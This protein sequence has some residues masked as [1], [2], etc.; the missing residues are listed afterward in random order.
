ML[1]SASA[2]LNLVQPLDKCAHC[3]LAL[4]PLLFRNRAVGDH[5]VSKFLLRNWSVDGTL[6]AYH[7]DSYTEHLI[8]E[9]KGL[10]TICQQRALNTMFGVPPAEKRAVE[11][12]FT[13]RVDTPA[14]QALKMMLAE[15]VGALPASYREAWAKFLIGLPA[16]M[17]ETLG[18]YGAEEA[19]K[20]LKEACSIRPIDVAM[21]DDIA[22]NMAIAAN[23]KKYKRNFVRK[24]A[25]GFTED[26]TKIDPILSMY[27]RIVRFE[28]GKILLGDR[29]LLANPP[30][31]RP[32]GIPLNNSNCVII[33]PISHD[34]VFFAFWNPKQ[35]IKLRRVSRR[36]LA[37]TINRESIARCAR[38]IFSFD[39]SQQSFI[40]PLIIQR[41]TEV[42]DLPHPPP[43]H[44]SQ[45]TGSKQIEE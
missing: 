14:S 20:S 16:R 36:R 43:V 40:E 4:L 22:A 13:R 15:G 18:A 31:A 29:P 32:C 42:A 21:V 35:R 9:P 8:A 17:P 41:F 26:R 1:L 11:D 28:A 2:T 12:H 3:C 23:M 5:F 25:V 33:L 39:C 38:H 19:E 37:E 30:T 44:S 34:A 6:I 27:W 7:W 45:T 10:D 24:I